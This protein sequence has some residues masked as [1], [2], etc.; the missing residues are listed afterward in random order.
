M[1]P[2]ARSLRSRRDERMDMAEVRHVLVAAPQELQA[3]QVADGRRSR[4]RRLAR[5]R[6]SGGRVCRG[7]A[8]RLAA[9]PGLPHRGLDADHDR[10]V[11]GCPGSIRTRLP[12]R[13]G[14]WPDLGRGLGPAHRGGPGPHLRAARPGRDTRRAGSGRAVLGMAD[15]RP[16]HRPRRHPRLS[17]DHLRRPPVETADPHG[18]GPDRRTRRG[19]AAGPRRADPD[20]RHHPRHRASLA[21][22]AL[23]PGRGLHAAHGDHRRYRIGQKPT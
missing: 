20:R 6:G 15:I 11:A 21:P 1:L 7:L 4:G 13:P 17:P 18:P 8:A 23:P 9:R 19:A 12:G 2:A 22:R 14:T 5:H 10:G 3:G 16:H